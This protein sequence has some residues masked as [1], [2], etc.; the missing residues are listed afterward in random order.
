MPR[1]RNVVQ[2]LRGA[3]DVR[4][5][6]GGQAPSTA[7][8]ATTTTT[9][10]STRPAAASST[11]GSPPP[12]AALERAVELETGQVVVMEGPAVSRR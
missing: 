3:Q 4:V 11:T 5:E 8:P 6:A 12:A 7:S 10:V 2:K 9:P 1:T